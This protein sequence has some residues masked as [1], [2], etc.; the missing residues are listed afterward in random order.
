MKFRELCL[1]VCVLPY[2]FM[3]GG[4]SKSNEQERIKSLLK[5]SKCILRIT[6]HVITII[7]RKNLKNSDNTTILQQLY[8]SLW[9]NTINHLN[10]TLGTWTIF[11]NKTKCQIVE[12]DRM[13]ACVKDKRRCCKDPI[14]WSK[15]NEQNDTIEK[16]PHLQ[17]FNPLLIMLNRNL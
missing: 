1:R 7:Y 14:D 8:R 12:Y 11:T 5:R 2:A 3:A 9:S 15:K 13:C 16:Y 17:I 6:F 4:R 10:L